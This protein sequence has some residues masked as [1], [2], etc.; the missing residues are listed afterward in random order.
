MATGRTPDCAAR[1]GYHP[2]GDGG[3]PVQA[4]EGRPATGGSQ[5]QRMHVGN[6][7][8]ARLAWGL[9][10]TS[11]A[12][13]TAGA[14]EPCAEP[15]A[16]V[17][18]AHGSVEVRRASAAGWAPA[19]LDDALCVGDTLRTLAESRAAL[20]LPDATVLRVDQ[21]SALSFPAPRDAKRTWLEVLAGAIHVISRDPRAL[22]VLTPFANAGIDGTEFL[23]TVSASDTRLLVLE[24]RVTVATAA[25]EARVASGEAVRA[26]AGAAPVV[27]RELRPRDAVAWTLYYPPVAPP[28]A[29]FDAGRSTATAIRLLAAGQVEPAS[30]ELARIVATE[31]GNAEALAL[32]STIALARDDRERARRLAAAASALAPG[33]SAALL[34][35]SY[36]QQADFDLP[37]AVASLEAA[38]AAEPANSLVLARLAELRFGSGD[39]P[40]ARRL[41]GD[42]AR[43]DPASAPALTVQGFAELAAGRA[44]AARTAFTAALVA[45]SSAPAP[46]LGRALAAIRG[47]DLAGGREELETAVVLDPGNALVRSY[48][49]KAYH[50]ERRDREAG[51]QLAI[52][53][54]LD[55]A[56]PTPWFYDGVR[57]QSVNRPVEALADL[58]AAAAR[59]DNRAVYRSRLLLDADLAARSAAVGRAYRDL[60]FDEL[61]LR[62]GWAS[63]QLAP[64]DYSG[65]R[66]LADSY[67]A[68]PRHEL[69]RVNELQQAQ[70]L[71]PLNMTPVQAQLGET[72]L[73]ILDSAGP[74]AIGF[75]EFNP[76]FGRDGLAFQASGA[77][78]GNGTAGYDATLGGI[79]GR[80]SFSAGGYG[81][82]TDG[83]RANN[84]VD[85]T[86]G[87]ALVQF[88]ATPGTT[89]LA[90]VRATDRDQGDLALRFDPERFNPLQRQAE[91]TRSARVGLRHDLA[92]GSQ[93]LA[94]GSWQTADNDTTVG[95]TFSLDAEVDGYAGELQHLWSGAR[96]RLVSGAR[97]AERRLREQTLLLLPPPFPSSA[98]S[99]R[100]DSES[101]SGYAYATVEALPGLAVTAGL[102]LDHLDDAIRDTT[103]LNPKLGVAWQP[104]AGTTVRAAW[105]R[106]LQSPF[107]SRQDVQ[108]RLEPTPVAGFN[109]LFFGSAGEEASRLG[110]GIDQR[111]GERWWV[112][113]EAS[114]RELEIPYTAFLPPDF[115]ASELT[116]D[117][118]ERSARG[119]AYW[120]PTERLAASVAVEYDLRR[121]DPAFAPE[122]A[123]TAELGRVPLRLHWFHP[124]GLGL[125]A[126]ATFVDQRVQLSPAGPFDPVTRAT[127]DFWV[128]DASLAW[129]LPRRWGQLR[130]EGRNLTDRNAPFQDVD[131]ENPR[132]AP[133]RLVLLR[134]TASVR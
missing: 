49:G 103:R 74:S 42:A 5:G 132:I 77:A 120:T 126:T 15:R 92:P 116:A 34:A 65:H 73:F 86:V 125:G 32:E 36:V 68:L 10:L 27:A 25:G 89:L 106:T 109:Q 127:S 57:K 108:P 97:Y 69:A 8:P 52:A 75:N 123:I 47:G 24:G 113:V 62:Q 128:F 100:S 29:A 23:V 4:P 110:L 81:F 39:L 43:L 37:G 121:N 44:D 58:T 93:L 28:E 70:L 94:L 35:R 88:E 38:R 131:P 41:A 40:A 115:T 104:A 13:A 66:L 99:T 72:N 87:N 1:R 63:V 53:K 31:P 129:R 46:R 112:G 102:A 45:D 7:G 14:A 83:F 16:R 61:A 30:V 78:G 6:R 124:N 101:A 48:M 56:D 117:A 9:L 80:L 118:R 134:V 122:G 54:E 130:L 59:N 55:A 111:L 11:L 90:E 95:P 82:R 12:M 84:D 20:R 2:R 105:F 51:V 79:N 60:G 50:D 22:R 33:S 119:Y 85:V 26:T 17:V 133:E 64:G 71:Q 67:A 91:T 76:L 18:S 19:A 114:G 98:A 3:G 96:W 21:N 107:A